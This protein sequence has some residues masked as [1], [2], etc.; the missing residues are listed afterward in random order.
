MIGPWGRQRGMRVAAK[1]VA[2]IRSIATRARE[3]LG[4]AGRP[5]EMVDLLENRLRKHG[6]HYHIVSQA[7]IP[8]DAARAVPE[9]G[10]ILLTH[11]A[12]DGIH[13]GD[14]DCV[15]LVPHELGHFALGHLATF[16][17]ANYRQPHRVDE[18]S[19]IQADQFSHEFVMPPD[20]VKGACSSIVQIQQVFR[21]PAGDARIRYQVLREEGLL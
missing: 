15:L 16:A 9:R 6:I 11:E 14:P 20:V 8:G 21:V 3:L 19:E 17:R 7:K 5:I 10:L 1:D 4:L 12:Y 18:D 2:E 13:D